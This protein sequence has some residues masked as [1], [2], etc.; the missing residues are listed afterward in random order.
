MRK[1]VLLGCL[2]ILPCGFAAGGTTIYTGHPISGLALDSAANAYEASPGEIY[3]WS[4]GSSSLTPLVS[5]A[6]YG[7]GIPGPIT[8]DITGNIYGTIESTSTYGDGLV[9]EYVAATNQLS[10][11]ASFTGANGATPTGNLVVDHNGDVFGTTQYGGNL[12]VQNSNGKGSG[13]VYEIVAGSHTITSLYTFDASTDT[14]TFGP[15]G[16]TSTNPGYNPTGGLSEDSLGNLY[17]TTGAG[18]VRNGAIFKIAAGTN[19][20]S[21][22]APCY[23]VGAMSNGV[24]SDSYGDL[25]GVTSTGTIEKLRAGATSL[26]LLGTE[27]GAP[28]YSFSGLLVDPVGDVF[29]MGSSGAISSTSLFETIPGIGTTTYAGAPGTI[30]GADPG[31]SLL[32]DQSGNLYGGTGGSEAS[33][34]E[35]TQSGYTLP[36]PGSIT[37]ACGSILCCAFPRKSRC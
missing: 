15:G 16:P 5:L 2:A 30:Y 1:A 3:E 14:I 37:I 25:Y 31:L 20:L 12:S 29:G 8:T 7:T 4:N 11:L 26:T 28:S 9:Y 24:T 32:A 35:I 23:Q 34:F 36:E 21:I 10:L 22:L 27:T 17:G 33:L 13:T 6:G 18:N 19:K